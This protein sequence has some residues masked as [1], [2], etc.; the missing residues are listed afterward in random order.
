[1]WSHP[2]IAIRVGKTWSSLHGAYKASCLGCF[3]SA[4]FYSKLNFAAD[5]EHASS[6]KV[7]EKEHLSSAWSNYIIK[8]TGSDGIAAVTLN[9]TAKR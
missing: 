9:Y 5:K 2:L 6:E 8:E 3:K 1:M 4:H 7:K